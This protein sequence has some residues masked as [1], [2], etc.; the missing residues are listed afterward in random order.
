MTRRTL[1]PSYPNQL[2]TGALLYQF[3]EVGT[4]QFKRYVLNHFKE[5]R[6]SNRY[7]IVFLLF[8]LEKIKNIP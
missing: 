7:R 3:N 2:G 5:L 8:A 6:T 1:I 4:Y